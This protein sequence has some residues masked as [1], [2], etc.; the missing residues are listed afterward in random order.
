MNQKSFTIDGEYI[1]VTQHGQNDYDIYFRNADFGERGTLLDVVRAFADW[2][3]WNTSEPS[4]SFD[5]QDR[6]ISDPWLDPSARFPLSSAE[7]CDTYGMDNV[8]Q[9]VIDACELL[10]P[11]ERK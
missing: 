2:Q 5:W 8:L 6:T 1:T 11:M 7:S 4:V 3:S 9:F 10:R